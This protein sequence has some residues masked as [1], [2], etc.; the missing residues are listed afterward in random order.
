V[1]L[2]ARI[3]AA[4]RADVAEPA[5][6]ADRLALHDEFD[7][8]CRALRRHG[9][10]REDAE[11]LAQDVLVVAWRRRA[12]FDRARS[13]RAWLAGIAARLAR[14]FLKRRWREVPHGQIDLTDPALSG[15]DRVDAARARGLLHAALAVLP[16]RHRAAILLHDVEGLAP[17]DVARAMGIPLATAYTRLRRAR[18]AF[19][20]GVGAN[21]GR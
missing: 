21:P 11:D 1:K 19:A 5:D 20:R 17:T 3:R 6:F 4:V 2:P 15:E 10:N 14:D 7:H 12:D 18:I 9:V 8:V 16:E 13:L